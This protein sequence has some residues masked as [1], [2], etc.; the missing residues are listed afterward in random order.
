A[1]L[2]LWDR[3]SR[4]HLVSHQST[5]RSGLR[6]V[7]QARTC[8]VEFL[9][10]RQLRNR[11]GS[12]CSCFNPRRVAL[13]RDAA[14]VRAAANPPWR[15]D[16]TRAVVG[17]AVFDPWHSE[18][19]TRKPHRLVLVHR[20]ADCVRHYRGD[21]SSASVT[22]THARKPTICPACRDRS[23]RNNHVT[24]E[25][26]KTAVNSFGHLYVLTVA[27]ALLLTGCNLAHGKP[28]Q[29]SET[30]APNE[31]TDFATLYA[32][33]CA[34]CHG[35]EGRGGAARALGDPVYLAIADDVAVQKATASGIRGTAMPGFAQSAGGM[36]TDKQI[37]A[38]T[39]GIRSRWGK[40]GILEG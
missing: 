34:G 24:R 12:A 6:A 39:N 18:S 9:P 31:I 8:P 35:A 5:C 37:D 29:D 30:V 38:I 4:E 23:S 17:T 22:R 32:Q 2:Y 21:G 1:R 36:L 15:F 14:N 3:E 19:S 16:R 7:P 40:P 27:G 28:G 11:C 25:R 13:R 26:R 33:N 20:F 10:R